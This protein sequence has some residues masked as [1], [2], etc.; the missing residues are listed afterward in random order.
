MESKTDEERRSRV[1]SDP[2][3]DSGR[4]KYTLQRW[5]YK[6]CLVMQSPSVVT[7]DLEEEEHRATLAGHQIHVRQG[8]FDER[9]YNK[10]E[11][12]NPSLSLWTPR[13]WH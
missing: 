4:R 12:D 9:T 6:L 11:G 1:G 5:M 8:L 10:K 2:A 7:F 3:N 13:G